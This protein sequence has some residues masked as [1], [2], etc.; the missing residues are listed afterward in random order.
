MLMR[1]NMDELLDMPLE[2]DWITAS[3]AYTCNPMHIPHYPPS[4]FISTGHVDSILP[5]DMNAP[6]L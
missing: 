6:L 1:K 2:T 3:H 5:P 4:W